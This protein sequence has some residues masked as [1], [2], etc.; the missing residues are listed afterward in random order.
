MTISTS[1]VSGNEVEA[2]VIDESQ[3]TG[4]GVHLQQ[5]QL[6][7]SHA[8]FTDNRATLGGGI[9]VDEASTLETEHSILA[10]NHAATGTDGQIVG[11]VISGGYN[12]IGVDFVPAPGPGDQLCG[13]DSPQ[14]P[15]L[16]PLQDNGGFTWTH[17]LL[18]GSPAI[19]AGDATI[20]S[21]TDQ[22]HVARPVDGDHD[23]VA[24]ID[25]GATERYYGEI[26]GVVFDDRKENG[27][28]DE[29]AEGMLEPGIGGWPIYLDLNGNGASD[30]NE[31]I[32]KTRNDDP[33]TELDE[34]GQYSF[35]LLEPRGYV[36]T[37]DSQSGWEYTSAACRNEGAGRWRDRHRR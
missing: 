9:F 36:V 27:I 3:G 31:P 21:G 32:T 19:D 6:A 2:D 24:V 15:L 18:A 13:S 34:T 22:R 37:A 1:T 11:T 12:L 23:G 29:W 14:C 17:E 35:R 4:G 16:G 26:H 25:I 5:S 8:T 7:M 30:L 20:T 10:G 28:R 33:N